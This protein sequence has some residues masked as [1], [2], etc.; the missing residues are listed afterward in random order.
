MLSGSPVVYSD[1]DSNG[2]RE[3]RRRRSHVPVS[4]SIYEWI[5]LAL[6]LLVPVA[7]TWI[8]GGVRLW[9]V[10][11]LMLVVFLAAILYFARPLFF[12][13]T[14][15]PYWPTV[16]VGLLLFLAYGFVT[17]PRAAAPDQAWTAMLVATSV[18]V[19]FLV[20]SG[21]AGEAGRWRWLL[22]ALF[23]SISIMAWYAIVQHTHESRLVLGYERPEQYGMRASGAYFCPNHFANLLALTVPMAFAVACIRSAGFPLRLLAGYTMLVVLPPLYLSGSR[24]AWLGVIAGI[25]AMS[26]FLGLRRGIGRALLLIVV[27][28]IGLAVLGALA[29]LLLPLVQERVLNA[30]H[31]NVRINLWRDTLTMIADRPWLGVGAGGFRW[32]YPHYWHFLAVYTDPEFAHN[33]HLQLV[34]EFGIVGASILFAVVAWMLFGFARQLR[35]GDADR[36]AYLI[37]GFVGAFVAYTVHAAFDYNFHIYGNAQ[38]LAALGGITVAVLHSGGHIQIPPRLALG[39]GARWSAVWALV[40]LLLLL[41]TVRTVAGYG[42][43]LRGD[44]QREGVKLEDAMA[45]YQ[46]ALRISPA[47]GAAHRGIAQ[48]LSSMAYWNVVPEDKRE[49]AES[50]R[51]EFQRAL[52]INPWDIDARFGLSRIYNT[53]GNPEQGLSA[54]RELVELVPH[55]RDYKLELGLQLR[56]MGQYAEALEVFREVQKAKNTEQVRL[57]IQFLQRKLAQEK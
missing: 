9:S 40:P 32:V 55:Q 47:N 36:G 26:G 44:L 10:G 14:S 16:T 43:T 51:A 23:I 13:G 53:L 22:A 37:A 19:A 7:G 39:S 15:I 29:W 48:C 20:W 2:K 18:V 54:L 27:V 17:I 41:L 8:F 42:F 38:T 50:A 35:S 31:G 57:N 11:P 30:L 21:L 52:E 56:S 24:S 49:Q 1:L 28:A 34:A 33:D 45:S 4:R 5:A 46:T 3:P 12:R 6:L 25:L